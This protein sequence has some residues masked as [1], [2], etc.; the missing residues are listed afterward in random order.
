MNSPRPAAR[1][2]AALALALAAAIPLAGSA[3]E[4]QFLAGSLT[5]APALPGEAVS[6]VITDTTGEGFVFGCFPEIFPGSQ[7][8]APIPPFIGCAAVLF[9]VAPH[10]SVGM[11]W[12]QTIGGGTAVPPGDYWLRFSSFSPDFQE[13]RSDW[14]CL[15]IQLP[16]EPTLRLLEPARVGADAAMEVVLPGAT[17]APYRVLASLDSSQPLALP[18]LELFLTHDALFEQ[19]L[20]PDN[21]VFA[22][23]SGF[24]DVN[25]RADD[26]ALHVPDDPS[27]AYQGLVAQAVIELGGN[28]YPTNAVA[29]TVAP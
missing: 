29:I 11:I 14:F 5:P 15:S 21:G 2:A 9:A 20:Y 16:D 25:G 18:G 10:G 13:A 1:A 23:G 17:F 19:T 8:A 12:D 3:P 6:M 7:T 22:G 4:A 28:L 26:V 27:L 24:L